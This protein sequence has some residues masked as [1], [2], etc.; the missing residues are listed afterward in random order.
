M[1]L[2]FSFGSFVTLITSCGT[3]LSCFKSD[4]LIKRWGTYRVTLVT[5]AH[6]VIISLL[7]VSS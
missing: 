2:P 1:G 7:D 6:T 5:T 3:V 4:C